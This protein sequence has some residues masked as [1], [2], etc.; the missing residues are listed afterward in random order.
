M[1]Y[2]REQAASDGPT[3]DSTKATASNARVAFSLLPNELKPAI[4]HWCRK[5]SGKATRRERVVEWYKL[6]ELPDVVGRPDDEPDLSVYLVYWH[7][8]KVTRVK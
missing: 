1:S 6:M 2:R 4:L 7:G 5:K 3:S 8:A